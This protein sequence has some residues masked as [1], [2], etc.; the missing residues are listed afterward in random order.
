[1]YNKE[2]KEYKVKIYRLCSGVRGLTENERDKMY[3]DHKKI[4]SYL[5]DSKIKKDQHLLTNNY[6]LL[7]KKL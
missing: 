5:L 3:D 4:K 1:M 2:I 7:G 6:S